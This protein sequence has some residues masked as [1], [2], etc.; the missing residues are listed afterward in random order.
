M[1]IDSAGFDGTVYDYFNGIEDLKQK[2]IRFV[3][4]AS[5]RIQEDYL[6]IMRYFR[7]WCKRPVIVCDIVSKDAINVL[8][9]V[10]FLMPLVIVDSL[11][12]CRTIPTVTIQTRCS[13]SRTTCMALQVSSYYADFQIG[14]ADSS[15]VTY[16]H[17]QISTVSFA[18]S[19]LFRDHG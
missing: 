14:V 19:A 17:R 1:D 5:D 12:E 15:G 3:G 18:K 6:R 13:R 9:F 4:S 7:C 10:L 16:H 11:A 8:L 2:K